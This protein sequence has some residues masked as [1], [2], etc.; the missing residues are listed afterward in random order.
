MEQPT[1]DIPN[2]E[3]AARTSE[4]PFKAMTA[5]YTTGRVSSSMPM[6]SINRPERQVGQDL[7]DYLPFND[8]TDYLSV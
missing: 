2:A 7:T 5:E 8:K 6:A 4:P 1:P 3:S